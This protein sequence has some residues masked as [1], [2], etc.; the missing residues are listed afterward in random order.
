MLVLILVAE[1]GLAIFL[2]GVLIIAIAVTTR[3]GDPTATY[4]LYAVRDTLI[5][6][7]VLKGVPRDNPWLESLYENVNS[8]LLHSNLLGGPRGWSLAAAV[9]HHQARH[10]NSG[11]KLSPLPDDRES[12]PEPISSLRS[13]LQDAL[14]HLT[15]HHMGI[16][17]QMDA[18]ERVERRIQREKA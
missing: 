12:C 13:D 6:A 10:P 1:A 18:R 17:I 4:K 3:H 7:S 8:I 5:E 2:L 11:K 14:E 15:R 16:F 9:G